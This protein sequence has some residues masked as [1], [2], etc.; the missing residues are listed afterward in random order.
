MTHELTI[1]DELTEFLL[2]TTPDGK[3]KVEIFLPS[4]NWGSNQLFPFW[5]QL[6]RMAKNTRPG[7]RL[8]WAGRTATSMNLPSVKT[9][10]PNFGGVIKKLNNHKSNLDDGIIPFGS[11]SKNDIVKFSS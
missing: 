2:Y 6:L 4:V 9:A 1:Q 5:K 10:T 11:S 3:V 8:S 7:I